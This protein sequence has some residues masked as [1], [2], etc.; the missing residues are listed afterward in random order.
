METL[1]FDS[2]D[3]A[4]TEDFLSRAY[5]R[6]SIGSSAPGAGRARIVRKGVPSVSVDELDLDFEMR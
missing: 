5:A 1:T 6:M 2:A 3:L 4:V